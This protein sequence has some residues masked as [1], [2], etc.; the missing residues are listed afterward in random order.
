MS[1]EGDSRSQSSCTTLQPLAVLSH[2]PP[3]NPQCFDVVLF[4]AP[5]NLL[6]CLSS[7]LPSESGGGGGAALPLS[8]CPSV[9]SSV[10][11]TLE[12]LT[13]CLSDE[14]TQ[15]KY[16]LTINSLQRME[17]S[18]S[19][20]CIEVIGSQIKSQKCL[21]DKWVSDFLGTLHN[22]WHIFDQSPG[23]WVYPSNIYWDPSMSSGLLQSQGWGWGREQKKEDRPVRPRPCPWAS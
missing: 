4:R 10:P 3:V 16:R 23:M 20:S 19:G 7:P 15:I 11:E 12:A 21:L 5:V 14:R 22:K 2:P 6:T 17:N 1:K 8:L 9:P 18:I 13:S